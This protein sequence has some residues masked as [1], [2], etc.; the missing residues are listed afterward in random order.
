MSVRK[1]PSAAEV[2]ELTASDIQE[3]ET[4]K[5]L[6]KSRDQPFVPLGIL[7]TVG[8]LVYGAYAYKNRGPMSTSRY[9]MRLRVVAQS[10]VVGAIM[11][12]VGYTTLKEKREEKNS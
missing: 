4:D 7:G 2:A 3:S 5:L 8:A 11:I 6:R 9:L 1:A 10:M 12:G